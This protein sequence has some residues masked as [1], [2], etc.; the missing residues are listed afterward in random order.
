MPVN[1]F[2]EGLDGDDHPRNP[3]NPRNDNRSVQDGACDLEH[4]LPGQARQLAQQ[5]AVEAEEQ[6]Q[7]LGDGEDVLPVRHV[8][9]DNAGDMLGD[10][11]R[12]LLVA[13]GTEAAASAGES[14]E[15]L[16]E[17]PGAADACKA[18][19]QIAAGEELL[20]GP[21]DDGTPEAVALLEAVAIDAAELVKVAIEQAPQRALARPARAV[22]V[23]GPIG[24]VSR[25][26][27]AGLHS[28]G[29]GGG[30][31][32]GP[33]RQTLRGRGRERWRKAGKSVVRTLPNATAA[34]ESTW[35]SDPGDGNRSLQ[36]F[37]PGAAPAPVHRSRPSRRGGRGRRSTARRGCSRRR[38]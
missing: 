10:D 1:Q 21:L 3:R 12:P 4:R 38:R 11:Q 5:R 34:A 27:H 20:D 14:D 28:C 35:G 30:G 13:T 32:R 8:L 22:D 23:C 29:G 15:E 2:A 33:G 18:L 9:A 17:A 6:A 31:Y 25:A 36:P 19:V 7:T 24:P 16:V 26:P 37:R